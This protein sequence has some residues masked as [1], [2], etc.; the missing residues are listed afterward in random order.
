MRMLF[1]EFERGRKRAVRDFLGKEKEKVRHY[2][3]FVE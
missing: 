3:S 2:G 1:D